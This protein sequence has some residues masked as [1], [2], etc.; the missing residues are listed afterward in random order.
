MPPPIPT[1]QPTALPVPTVAPVV[2]V[3]ASAIIEP[4][5]TPSWPTK[6]PVP[7]AEAVTPTATPPSDPPD[8]IFRGGLERT[9]S[10][11]DEGVSSFNRLKWKFMAEGAEVDPRL[12]RFALYRIGKVQSSPAIHD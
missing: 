3:V 1:P 4:T 10:Y 6:T 5:A 2:D 7:T 12:R 11:D 9:G 8:V